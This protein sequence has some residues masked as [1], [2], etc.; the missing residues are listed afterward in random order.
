MYVPIWK[1]LSTWLLLWS[2]KFYK[3]MAILTLLCGSECWFL[4]EAKKQDRSSRDLFCNVHIYIFFHIC[5]V[6]SMSV[7][8]NLPASEAWGLH[9]VFTFKNVPVPMVILTLPSSKQQEPNKDAAWSA[10]CESEN[11]EESYSSVEL[12]LMLA[13]TSQMCWTCSDQRLTPIFTCIQ[14]SITFCMRCLKTE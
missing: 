14:T 1:W 13:T 2:F 11:L 10:T 8:T 4:Q 3:V 12:L 7:H 9:P 6:D 5:V